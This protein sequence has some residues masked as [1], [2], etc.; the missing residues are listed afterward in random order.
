[1][2]E[3]TATT[4]PVGSRVIVSAEAHDVWFGGMVAGTVVPSEEAMDSGYAEEGRVNVLAPDLDT[5]GMLTQYV[6]PED[7]TLVTDD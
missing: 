7:L 2:S 5:G 3:G 6:R 1:M 4:F